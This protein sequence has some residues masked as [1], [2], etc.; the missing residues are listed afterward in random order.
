MALVKWEP[1]AEMASGVLKLNWNTAHNL[2]M[3][4]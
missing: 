2:R 3:Q 4:M 1:F